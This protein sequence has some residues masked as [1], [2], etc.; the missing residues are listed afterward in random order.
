MTLASGWAGPPPVV[1]E[2]MM[3]NCCS[4]WVSAK[5][6]L[7]LK[8]SLPAG[9]EQRKSQAACMWKFHFQMVGRFSELNKLKIMLFTR[10]H[11][12]L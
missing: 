5:H 4:E 7:T 3:S 10:L 9:C 2:S 1:T 6:R 11:V 12:V 8:F